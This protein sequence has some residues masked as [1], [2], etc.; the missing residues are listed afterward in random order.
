M[1]ETVQVLFDEGALARNGAVRLTKPL[2]ELE[3]PPTVMVSFLDR[4]EI[5]A[6][7]TGSMA[8]AD[9]QSLNGAARGSVPIGVNLKSNA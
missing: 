1:E 8:P 6:T 4:Y 2:N 9:R 3:I 5:G 7:A